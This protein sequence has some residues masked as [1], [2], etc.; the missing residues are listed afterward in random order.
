MFLRLILYGFLI[1]IGYRFIRN[2]VGNFLEG[3]RD[4]P[5][6]SVREPRR[7]QNT[8]RDLNKADIEDASFEEIDE[9]SQSHS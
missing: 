7:K 8:N 9:D 6:D 1:F 5:A 2:V 4:A 3:Q